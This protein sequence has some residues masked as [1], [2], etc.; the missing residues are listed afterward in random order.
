MER[1][2]TDEA[3]RLDDPVS[4]QSR[5]AIDKHRAAAQQLFETTAQATIA[6]LK[7]V[8]DK[9][10]VI[11][12]VIAELNTYR[13]RADLALKVPKSEREPQLLKDYRPKV[14]E[15]IKGAVGVWELALRAST[16]ADTTIKEL[17]FVKLMAWGARE[18]AGNERASITAALAGKKAI[19]AE[20]LAANES[21]RA[22]VDLL[23]KQLELATGSATSLNE[24]QQALRA[25]LLAAIAKAKIAIFWRV[26][27]PR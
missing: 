20:V 10:P 1:V 5:A 26:S 11:D 8:A 2:Y 18:I 21:R 14:T 9:G 19:A 27:F 6:G 13:S 7:P 22:Q 3:L 25:P 23:W 4:P 16:E 17:G 24:K 15:A 12:A